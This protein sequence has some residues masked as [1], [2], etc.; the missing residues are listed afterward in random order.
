[1]NLVI[2]VFTVGL[3]FLVDYYFFQAIKTAT[4]KWEAPKQRVLRILYWG[5]T[6]ITIGGL[7]LFGALRSEVN[8][9]VLR[10]FILLIVSLNYLPKFFG[11]IVL[12]LGDLWSGMQSLVDRLKPVK[13][14]E[15]PG[16]VIKRSEFIAKTAIV[17]AGIPFLTM[18][19][20]ILS[21]AHDYRVRK[22]TV[23]VKGLPSGFE[24][25]TIGQ[26]SDIHSGSFFNKTAVQGGVDLL[27]SENPDLVTFTGD[28]VNVQTAE[29]EDYIPVFSKIKAELGV[30]SVT[31]N[32][33]YGDYRRWS[34]P[35]AKERNFRDLIEAHNLLGWD[36]LLNE[37]RIIKVGNDSI[38][39]LGI[40][41]WGAGRFSKYGNLEKA[42][43][44]TESA[45]SKI[46]LSHDPSHWEAQVLPNYQDIDLSLAG[47]THG[48]QFGIEV[49]NLKWSPAQYRYKQW[50]GLYSYGNQ[51]IYVNRGYGFIGYP[52]R[53]GMPPEITILTLKAA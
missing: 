33:D 9:K 25:I 30:Y 8:E 45:T 23:P 44:G 4:S 28:L 5:L 47:H 43:E 36:L 37:N 27:N 12:A 48:F 41:N 13:K 26:I 6:V 10:N 3:F 32:H 22:I 39:L 46:L 50:A 29:V 21:G 31:G 34:S 15:L 20:G 24:G 49:G 16:K 38:A 17:G 1:V 42:Y 40:E 18:S 51:H 14:R 2:I 11:V 53:I 19:F 35:E 7:V 52:G